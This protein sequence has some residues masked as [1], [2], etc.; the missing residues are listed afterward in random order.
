MFL[1]LPSSY[2]LA[3]TRLRHDSNSD[4]GAYKKNKQY[5]NSIHS[6]NDTRI[7]YTTI[8]NI[9]TLTEHQSVAK[10]NDKQQQ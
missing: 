5:T 6:R 2:N 1:L 10:S 7:Q 8:H 4:Q 9:F 3:T